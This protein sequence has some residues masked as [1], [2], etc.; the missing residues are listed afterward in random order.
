MF[1]TKVIKSVKVKLCF[2]SNHRCFF[3]SCDTL[4]IY[5]NVVLC[6]YFRGGNKFTSRKVVFNG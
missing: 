4:D 2:Y 3:S 5:G 6:C 1:E